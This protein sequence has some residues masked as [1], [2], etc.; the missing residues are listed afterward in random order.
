MTRDP[1]TRPSPDDLATASGEPLLPAE[2]KLIVWSLVFGAVA[3]AA[4]IWV[5][6]AFFPG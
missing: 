6:N 4:L 3:L 2:V 5:S 1:G